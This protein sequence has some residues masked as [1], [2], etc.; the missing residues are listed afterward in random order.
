MGDE[1]LALK[2]Q[3]LGWG[4][5]RFHFLHFSLGFLAFPWNFCMQMRWGRSHLFFG[6]FSLHFV[7]NRL[8]QYHD[9]MYFLRENNRKCK[10]L[11]VFTCENFPPQ[12]IVIQAFSF[13]VFRPVFALFCV[14][15]EDFLNTG[16]VETFVKFRWD[17]LNC[18]QMRFRFFICLTFCIFLYAFSYSFIHMFCK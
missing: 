17:F 5:A 16:G 13:V 18:M 12:K 6:C 4:L 8:S 11:Y 2:N 15:P 7:T 1:N 10:E 3:W 14:V 9:V